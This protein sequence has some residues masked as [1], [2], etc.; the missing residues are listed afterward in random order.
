MTDTVK[1]SEMRLGDVVRLKGMQAFA[2]STVQKIDTKSVH[3]FRPYVHTAD[4]E[5]TGGVLC[6]VG[7]EQYAISKSDKTQSYTLVEGGKKLK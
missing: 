7:I 2:D 3:L 5:Y 6:Y 4:F 1:P